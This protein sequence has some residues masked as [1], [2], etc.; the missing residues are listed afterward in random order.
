MDAHR[1]QISAAY[2]ERQRAVLNAMKNKYGPDVMSR[3]VVFTTQCMDTREPE[4]YYKGQF[5]NE[6]EFWEEKLGIPG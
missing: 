5:L 2:E 1:E 4:S 3:Q 6:L